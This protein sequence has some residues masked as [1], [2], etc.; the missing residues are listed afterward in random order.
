[1][2]TPLLRLTTL[3][4]AFGLAAAVVGPTQAGSKKIDLRTR[5]GV[6]AVKGEWRFTTVRLAEVDAK[7]EDGKPTKTYTIEPKASGK[8]YDVSTWELCDPTTLGQR[9]GLDQVSFGWYRIKVTIPAEA[10]GKTVVFETTVDDYGEIW[11]DG[12]LPRKVGDSGGSV[13]AGFNA[14]NRLTLKGAKPGQVVSLAIFAINGPI[15]ALPA[16]RLFLRET[17]LELIDP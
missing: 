16:N 17:F 2:L 11:V 7:T 8:D 10:A 15:S 3:A 9:R 4:L 6:A 5:E 1:M 12:Q 13:V 14:P